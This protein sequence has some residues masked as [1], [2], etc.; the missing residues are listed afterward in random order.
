[1][2]P[3][4]DDEPAA[5]EPE[6]GELADVTIGFPQNVFADDAAIRG[7]ELDVRGHVART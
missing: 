5:A 1:M 2:P 3:R 4:R 6:I 7:A